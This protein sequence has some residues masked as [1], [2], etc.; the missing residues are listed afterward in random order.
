MDSSKTIV[1][2][3]DTSG[4]YALTIPDYGHYWS[5]GW[6]TFWL[7]QLILNDICGDGGGPYEVE[8]VLKSLYNPDGSANFDIIWYF[9][10]SEWL[11]F[12]PQYPAYS[13][14]QYFND[15]S[16]LPYYIHMTAED[17]L[18]I[19]QDICPPIISPLGPE[20]PK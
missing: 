6:N 12:M 5:T 3:I 15:Q 11:Y 8:D 2:Y 20:I 13:T 9:D 17:R 18:E 4:N 10:G 19:T 16:S 7:P 14:L 1:F